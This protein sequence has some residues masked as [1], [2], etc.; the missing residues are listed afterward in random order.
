M[1]AYVINL[2]R[3]PER[4]ISFQKNKFPFEVERVSGI[5]MEDAAMGCATTHF[6]IMR[7]QKEFPFAIFEDD[8]VLVHPWEMV[9]NAMSQLPDDWDALWLGATL[10]APIRRY[11]K[12]LFKLNRAYCTHA[13]IYNSKTMIDYILENFIKE[14]RKIIDVFYHNDVQFKFKC[15]ITYPMMALQLEGYSDIM[16]RTPEDWEY[17][18]RLDC[19]NKFTNEELNR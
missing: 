4:M 1:K 8:C 7:T 16:H 10:D 15:F 14:D 13:I 5:E 12:N 9:E 3:R 11:S 2:D 19:Y 18:W 17:G 6:N